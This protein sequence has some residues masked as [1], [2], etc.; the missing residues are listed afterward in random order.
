MRFAKF[1]IK[2]SQ[3]FPFHLILI[4]EFQEFLICFSEIQ[5]FP[6]FLK[7]F[8][9]NF[10]TICLVSKILELLAE[11]KA[12]YFSSEAVFVYSED[13]SDGEQK[14]QGTKNNVCINNPMFA[15]CYQMQNA[16]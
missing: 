1:S 7:L 8:P 10:S 16:C 9:G 2:F 13:G 15:E 5:Q 11:L 6:D 3:L 14:V 4:Q 12:F